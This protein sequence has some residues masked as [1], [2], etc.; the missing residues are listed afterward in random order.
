MYRNPD[1][2]LM[3]RTQIL[4]DT[5]PFDLLVGED[6]VQL[7]FQSAP[8]K[9]ANRIGKALDH[10]TKAARLQGVDDE[11]GFIRLIAAEE[12]LVVALFEWL[13]L[14]AK[15]LPDHS[16]FIRRYKDHRVKLAFYP[17]LSQL[18]FVLS[19]MLRHGITFEGL[20]DVLHWHTTVVRDEDKVVLRIA[21]SS[22]KFLTNFSPLD[23]AITQGE[24]APHEVLDELFADFKK[25][26][27][28]Q[29]R[30]TVRQFV[31]NRADFRNKLLY[32]D[33]SGIFSMEGTL[34]ELTENVFSKSLRDLLWCIAILLTNKPTSRSWGVVSQFVDLY[35][36]ILSEIK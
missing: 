20:E 36:K 5:A 11:M 29:H 9:V 6:I 28:D 13:K 23:I 4:L 21:D 35:R 17:V 15:F 22:G 10:Y 3:K 1:F 34:K 31:T 32:A 24:R 16:D 18:Q 25:M 7:I 14:N 33:D 12:E 30:M 19:D 27:T 26:V 2:I 8:T